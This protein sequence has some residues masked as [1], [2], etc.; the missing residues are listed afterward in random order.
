MREQILKLGVPVD[1]GVRNGVIQLLREAD[2]P[3]KNTEDKIPT[4]SVWFNKDTNALRGASDQRSARLDLIFQEEPAI[5]A[6][7][8][9]GGLN[10]GLV[11]QPSA[12]KFGLN[13]LEVATLRVFDPSTGDRTD[14]G[15]YSTT[16]VNPE[17][18]TAERL[19]GISGFND[20]LVARILIAER[21]LNEEEALEWQG[22]VRSIENG[23]P[24]WFGLMRMGIT[25]TAGP[26]P[27]A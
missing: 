13:G 9:E 16:P 7:V 8:L 22:T 6:Q 25:P 27:R 26:S 12:E 14:L 19:R 18:C 3:V 4:A 24:Q 1:Y 23:D 21:S 2:I 10:L 17:V 20:R 11:S 5:A 15:L